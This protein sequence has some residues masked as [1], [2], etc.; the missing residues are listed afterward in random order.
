MHDNA[1]TGS[2]FDLENVP[3]AIVPAQFVKAWKK[4]LSRP[5]EATRPET[6]D[7]APFFCEH[8]KLIIDPNCPG[9]LST[10]VTIVKRSD[11]DALADL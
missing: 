2:N 5:G 4:W 1:L 7:N 6:V 9:D 11:W 3:C 8:G 10:T